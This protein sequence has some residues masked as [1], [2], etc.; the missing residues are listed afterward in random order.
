MDLFIAAECSPQALALN[1]IGMAYT[2][3]DGSIHFA[4]IGSPKINTALAQYIWEVS[5]R[6]QRV[7]QENEL[8]SVG[9]HLNK[10][11]EYVNHNACQPSNIKNPVT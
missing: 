8:N 11:Y 6:G 4:N 7:V 9:D 1:L 5:W 3:V 10:A 2:A